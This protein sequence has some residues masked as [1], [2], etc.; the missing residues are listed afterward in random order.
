MLLR[1]F[2]LLLLEG[3]SMV[4]V[5]IDDILQKRLNRRNGAQACFGKNWKEASYAT[6]C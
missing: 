5:N 2:L 4:E 6:A 1:G 3:Q